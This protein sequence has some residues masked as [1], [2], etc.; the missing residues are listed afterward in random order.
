MTL[1]DHVL[2][3]FSLADVDGGGVFEVSKRLVDPPCCQMDLWE[4]TTDLEDLS[5][6]ARALDVVLLCPA[7]LRKSSLAKSACE[8]SFRK[9]GPE[10]MI[11]LRLSGV[12]DEALA[13]LTQDGVVWSEVGAS[14]AQG[15]SLYVD[16]D[17]WSQLLPH[18]RIT[19][20]PYVVSLLA[21][22]CIPS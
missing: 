13:G 18:L 17:V 22:C 8:L 9:W 20:F 15:T 21:A 6:E 14:Y 5:S 4:L 11:R 10:G 12:S 7:S 1:H 16:A 3:C 19:R 2:V